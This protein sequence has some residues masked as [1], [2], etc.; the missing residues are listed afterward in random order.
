MSRSTD[1][2]DA[3]IG[4]LAAEGMRG[5]T[6]RA[7]DRAAGLPEGSTSSYYRTRASLLQGVMDRLLE[8]DQ[9]E[10]PDEDLD[11]DEFVDYF[12]ETLNQWSTGGRLREIARYELILES[13]RRP[14][15][16]EPL[17]RQAEQIHQLGASM[18]RG[19]AGA[20]APELA[21]SLAPL[22]DGLL[23][24]QVTTPH[25]APITRDQIANLIRS[26]L[27]AVSTAKRRGN[28]KQ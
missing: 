20:A 4:T 7:V 17:A 9:L 2:A 24:R 19:V 22:L 10:A 25:A 15:L 1:I 28:R 18:L 11:F 26:Q 3:A 12:T 5:L 27:D 23:L 8:L 14:E 16:R 21:R 13:T 6:H